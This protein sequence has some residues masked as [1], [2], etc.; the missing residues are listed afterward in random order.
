MFSLGAFLLVLWCLEAHFAFAQQFPMMK[1]S[2]ETL[3]L[4]GPCF[5]ALNTTVECSDRLAK[6]VAWDASSVGLL[7][8]NGL[9][10]VCEDTCRQSLV[11]LR[12]RILGS[13]NFNTDAIQYSYL[14][15]PATYI[16]DR[17]LYFY[18]VS[19]YRDS[20]SGIFCDT[21]V[22]GWRNETDGSEAHFCHDCWLGPMSVQL[23][24]PIGFN[25]D[26]AKEFASLTRSCS[27]DAYAAPTPMPYGEMT[28]TLEN[29][30]TTVQAPAQDTA[31][32]TTAATEVTSAKEMIPSIYPLLE[33]GTAASADTT[34]GREKTRRQRRNRS[35]KTSKQSTVRQA[36]PRAPGTSEDCLKYQSFLPFELVYREADQGK[37]DLDDFGINDCKYT[38]TKH[39]VSL[40]SFLAWNP[41]LANTKDC[42]LQ[43]GCSYCVRRPF[44]SPKTQIIAPV[45][46]NATL[47]ST[48]AGIQLTSTP[49]REIKKGPAP[50]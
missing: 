30:T 20:S 14:S 22:A 16:V 5:E 39:S 28:A 42:K 15:F 12:K 46:S 29:V 25:E 17:Y 4:S 3:N 33:L 7:D 38:A 32:A 21:M 23:Q 40:E 10:D 8:Q 2:Y 44:S 19:C 35:K 26:R 18:D 34:E 11:D 13:C 36:N 31:T 27:V 48:A 24:S 9:A 1:M 43:R 49:S 6:H 37:K 50:P 47:N 41:S 45:A